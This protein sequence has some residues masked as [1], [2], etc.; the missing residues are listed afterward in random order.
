[1]SKPESPT[2]PCPFVYAN[3]QRCRGPVRRAKA[4]GPKRKFAGRLPRECVRNYRLWCTEKDDHAGIV[5]SF[6]GKERMQFD[7]GELPAAT[8][9]A[10]WGREMVEF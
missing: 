3:G 5:S 4:F 10:L 2:I 7:S 9:D 8:L 1:M 6:E